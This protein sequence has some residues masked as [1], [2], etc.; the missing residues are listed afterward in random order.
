MNLV[1]LKFSISAESVIRLFF[2]K[3]MTL[4]KAPINFYDFIYAKVNEQS[5]DIDL[6]L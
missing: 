4:L 5:A 6:S 1:P 2:P 3:Y